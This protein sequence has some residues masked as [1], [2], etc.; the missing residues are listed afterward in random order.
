[1]KKKGLNK[2]NLKKQ[3]ISTLDEVKMEAVKG[4]YDPSV[5]NSCDPC[6]TI[7]WTCPSKSCW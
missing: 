1:M 2:L 6:L 4:G 7:E 5:Q 3:T